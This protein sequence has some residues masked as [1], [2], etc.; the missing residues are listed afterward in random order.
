MSYQYLRRQLLDVGN[1]T[2]TTTNSSIIGAALVNTTATTM[3]NATNSS[4]G[5]DVTNATYHTGS[6]STSGSDPAAINMTGSSAADALII[7]WIV[8]V[9]GC[10]L[11]ACLMPRSEIDDD[12]YGS[13]DNIHRSQSRP[14]KK[15]KFDAEKRKALIE[16]SLTVKKVTSID[17]YGNLTL[18]ESTAIARDCSKDHHHNVHD[19]EEEDTTMCAICISPFDIGDEVAWSRP[20]HSNDD[21]DCRHVFVS[22]VVRP[23]IDSFMYLLNQ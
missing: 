9:V 10:L 3:L 19:N 7:I 4:V 18:G 1:T 16:H 21:P 23:C 22:W 13:D 20:K 14:K 6:N 15:K 17:E 5:Y 12:V 2:S 8:L 11:G